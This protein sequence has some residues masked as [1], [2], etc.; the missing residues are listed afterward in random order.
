LLFVVSLPNPLCCLLSSFHL[1]SKD[2]ER[3]VLSPD[4]DG[5]TPLHLAAQEADEALYAELVKFG[6]NELRVNLA[7][8]SAASLLKAALAR[9]EQED[10]EVVERIRREA[11]EKERARQESEVRDVLLH[12]M[13]FSDTTSRCVAYLG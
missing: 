5:N 1:L 4:A 3:L 11:E 7:A 9:E 10:A 12:Y 8:L 2:I 6:G 13:S